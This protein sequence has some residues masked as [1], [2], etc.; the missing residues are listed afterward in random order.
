MGSVNGQ[1]PSD[2]PLPLKVVVMKTNPVNCHSSSVIQRILVPLSSPGF[3]G[4]VGGGIAAGQA[5][6]VHPAVDRLLLT[7]SYRSYDAIV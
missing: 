1:Q 6:T 3:L 5:L 4:V 2:S 7:G